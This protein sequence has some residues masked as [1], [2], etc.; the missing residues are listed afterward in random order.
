MSSSSPSDQR[1]RLTASA[2][3]SYFKHRCDRLFRWNTVDAPYRGKS[4]I[5]W[6]VPT[7][8][9]HHSRPGIA[10]LMGAGDEFEVANVEQLVEVAG[11][12]NVRHQGISG[13]GEHRKMGVLPFAT[14]AEEFR[15][16]SFPNYIAQVEII[17]TPEQEARFLERFGLDPLHVGL[18]TARPDLLEV[19]PPSEPNGKHRLR[20]WDF[21]GSQKARHEHFVQVAYYSLLLEQALVDADLS[22]VEVD[23]AVATIRARTENVEFEL[24]PY[25]LAV[26]DFLRNRVLSLFAVPAADAHYH[27]HESCAMCEYFDMCRD[28]A[29][30]GWDLSRIPYISSESKRLL[31]A[32]GIATHHELSRLDDPASVDHLRTLSH[33][34]SVNLPRYVESARALHDGLARPLGTATLLMPLYEDVRIVVC[35]EQDAVTGRCFALGF[36][37]FEGWDAEATTVMGAEHVFIADAPEKEGEI[38][39]GFLRELNTLLRR[40]D[41]ENRAIQSEP[42]DVE[43]PVAEALQAQADADAAVEEFKARHP[44]ITAK[45]P[46]AEALK[47]Q[48]AALQ[49]QAK[50]AKRVVTQ[51]RKDAQWEQRKRMKRLHFY[52]YDQL[53]LLILKGVVE[54]HLFDTEY[55]GLGEEIAHLLLLF[56]PES[57][58]PHAETFRTVPGSVVTQVLRA[59]VALPTPYVYDLRSVSETYQP[60][61]KEGEEKGYQFRPRYGFAWE[62]SNQVAFERIHDLWNGKSFSPDPRDSSRD[63]AP[64]VIRAVIE[65]TVLNKLR[66]TD[67]VVRRLKQ[68]IGKRLILQKQPFLLHSGF[69]PIGVPALE[70]LRTFTLLEASLDELA[71]KSEHTLSV[72]DRTARLVCISGLRYLEGNDEADGSLWFTFDP[73]SRDARFDVGDFSLVVTPE[74]RPEILLGNIDGKLFEASFGRYDGFKVTLCAYDLTVDPPRVRLLPDDPQ[75]FRESVD[76]TE[77]CVLDKLYVDYNSKRTI[78]VLQELRGNEDAAHHIHQL[79]AHGTVAEWVPF[80]TNTVKLERELVE[81]AGGLR[82]VLNAGQWAAFHGVFG[83]PLSLVWGPPGTGK[84]YT[85]AHILIG[86]ALA[87]IQEKKPLRILVTAFTHHAI[88]NV[89]VKVAE[90]AQRYGIDPEKLTVGKMQGDDPNAADELLPEDIERWKDKTLATQVVGATPCTIAGATVWGLYKGMK[91]AGAPLQQWFDVVLVDEA[92]QLRTPDAL[93]AFAAG[94]PTGNIILAG[95][96]QQLPPIIHGEYPEE[97]ESMLGSIFAFMRH[98]LNERIEGE[99]DEME[100]GRIEGQVLFQLDENFRMNEPLTAYPRELLYRGRFASSNPLIRMQLHPEQCRAEDDP[101]S[102]ML[103]PDRPVVLCWYTPPRSFTARNAIEAELIAQ[104]AATLASSLIDEKT[105]EVYSGQAFAERGLG[106]LAPHRAQNSAIRAELCMHG[107]GADGRQLPLVDTVEK[108]QG[109]ER[110][111]VLVSYG[112]GD[113]EYAEAEADFLLSRNRFNVAATRGRHKLVVLCSDVVLD[114]VPDDRLVLLESMMLKDFRHYCSDGHVKMPWTSRECGEIVL[115]IQW[116]GFPA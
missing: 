101:L 44:R 15:S 36:K 94:K 62:H 79:I 48:R 14:L 106:I 91:E 31:R 9:R 63:M 88:N 109:K 21:K 5:G 70:A 19:L 95:D 103:D 47:E 68:E 16:G 22:M 11:E 90:L 80:I 32:S 10:L 82:S 87:A 113:Q 7:K 55:E 57:L 108:L 76:L 58:L 86:Y 41:A 59:T 53:D 73:A 75:K 98:R 72:E 78:V 71:V 34:L 56:P 4:G 28:E 115:N 112:V 50:D 81:R 84:T 69:D 67:S 100:K 110:D 83:T 85:V 114:V 102:L 104:L 96:D 35:A 97:H 89:L 92:S 1:F 3:A 26:D 45:N 111:V 13:D 107:F 24:A 39:L 38:L 18:G 77:V 105:G 66:A 23:T 51:A 29:D 93:I 37:T 43:P 30:A 8:R 65:Q 42:V 49:E 20:I 54:R 40:V 60:V 99:S 52:L 17:F 116:K 61:S 64:D 46:D 27:I 74:S 6:N 2:V 12:S 25:R 33:N